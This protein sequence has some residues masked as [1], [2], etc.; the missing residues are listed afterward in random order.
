MDSSE[1]AV[2]VEMTIVS[3]GNENEM[4]E[5]ELK[6]LQAQLLAYQFDK[7]LLQCEIEKLQS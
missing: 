1:M 4:S 7:D 6:I 5:K 3:S 2:D